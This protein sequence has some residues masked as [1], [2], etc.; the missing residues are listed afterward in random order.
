[1]W[2]C[3]QVWLLC[4]LYACT[5]RLI[6]LFTKAFF[7]HRYRQATHCLWKRISFSVV[8]LLDNA[9]VSPM[10]VRLW[11]GLNFPLVCMW[12]CHAPGIRTR[13]QTSTCASSSRKGMSQSKWDSFPPVPHPLPNLFR[14]LISP[15]NNTFLLSNKSQLFIHML[16]VCVCVCMHVCMHACMH[17]CMHR[18]MHMC[19]GRLT[20]QFITAYYES[21]SNLFWV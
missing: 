7:L 5:L 17:A 3:Y 21:W 10:L 15:S 19:G 4:S 11:R 18:C 9:A 14:N 16:C 2:G 1:M 13:R 6:H 12:S 8:L 20:E